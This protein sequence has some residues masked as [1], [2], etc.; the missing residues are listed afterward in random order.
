MKRFIPKRWAKSKTLDLIVVG[1]FV[2]ALP[3]LLPCAF[4]VHYTRTRKMGRMISDFVCVSCGT[5]LGLEA[6]RLAD[7]RWRANLS[8][9]SNG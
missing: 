5:L 4:I 9:M 6:I 2:L 3:I 7:E 8:E 1:S